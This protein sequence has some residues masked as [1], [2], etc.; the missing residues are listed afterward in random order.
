MNALLFIVFVALL[1]FSALCAVVE[2]VLFSL[3]PV[4][5]QRLRDRDAA[6]GRR[7]AKL[8]ANPSETL[9]VILIANTVVGVSIASL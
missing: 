2:T 7:V 1:A 5:I 4:E 8:L 6:A 9:L 3:S